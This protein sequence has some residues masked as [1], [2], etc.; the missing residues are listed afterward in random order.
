MADKATTREHVAQLVRQCLEE[1]KCVEIDGLGVF[2]RDGGGA[3]QFIPNSQPKI[4]LAYVEE[5]KPWADR[6][7]TD[8]EERGFAPWLDRRKLL[9]GQNWPRAIEEAIETSDFFVACFS[10]LSVRKKG[11][12]QS[13]IRYA[14]DCARRTPLDEAFLIPVRLDECRVPW[15]I[16]REIHYIDLFPD[17]NRGLR[18]IVSIVEKQLRKRRVNPRTT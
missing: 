10:H 16:R 4:F 7:F 15:R 2:Q 14:L 18:R 3:Y 12:F 13:E 5:D 17:W 8:L 6:L 9:P 11:A 1:G